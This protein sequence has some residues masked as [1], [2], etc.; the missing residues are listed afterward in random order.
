MKGL[1]LAEGGLAELL[2]TSA[3]WLDQTAE[4]WRDAVRLAGDALIAGGSVT[5]PYIDE[6]IAVVQE[7]GPYIVIVPGL[8]LAHAR[9]SP[10]VVRSGLSWVTLSNPVRFGH[11]END[12]VSVVVGLAAPDDESHII[13]L[14]T[15]A[16]LLSDEQRHQALVSAESPAAVHA[17]ISDFERSTQGGGT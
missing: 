9:P 12:P 14:S 7:L 11:P 15:L 10:S 13:A 5:E 16:E 4:D 2:P 3:I 6:M 8:A 17:I 1:T